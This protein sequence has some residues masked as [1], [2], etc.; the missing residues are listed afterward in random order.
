M[1]IL[2]YNMSNNSSNI[3]SVIDAGE[4]LNPSVSISGVFVKL[5]FD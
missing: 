3:A 4:L 5:T 1:R 2:I